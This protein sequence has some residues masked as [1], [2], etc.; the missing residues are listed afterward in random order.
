MSKTLFRLAAA[1]AFLCL[2]LAVTATAQD[3]NKTYRLGAGG[4][5]RIGNISGDIKVT[6]Y[7]GDAIIVKGFKEGRDRNLLDFEDRSN[8]S[9]VDVR[10]RYPKHCNC[11][12][13]IRFEVQVPRSVNYNFDSIASVSGNV[14]M[15]EVTG[16][17]HAN[18][19]S[20]EMRIESVSGTVSASSVS[21]DVKVEINRIDNADDMKFSS[22]S[23]N[24]SVKAPAN[25]DAN[26]KM[27]SVSGTLKTDFPIEIHKPEYGPGQSAK[28]SIGN[29]SHNLRLSTVSGNITLG[30]SKRG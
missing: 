10:A 23:G 22:V 25:L 30:Y 4:S 16:K 19:V 7:D 29:G 5:V 11:N 28:G 3:F 20:G 9:S 21:G 26:I 6:G 18:S 15:R 1:C 2:T 13:D 17:V 27:S 14:E 8:E 12:A 24:L